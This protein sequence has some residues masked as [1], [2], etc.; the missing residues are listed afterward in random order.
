MG[1]VPVIIKLFVSQLETLKENA[2]D[3][4]YITERYTGYYMTV[5][6]L[7][8]NISIVSMS[9]VAFAFYRLYLG[10]L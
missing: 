10:M 9:Q 2:M 5:N 3:K 8:H 6:C 7:D 1:L 4:K